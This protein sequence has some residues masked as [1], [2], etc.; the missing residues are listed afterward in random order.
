M[1]ATRGRA[2]PWVPY[3]VLA[4]SACFWGSGFLFGKIALE[5][6]GVG[7]MLV[8][9]FLFGCAALAPFALRDRTPVRRAHL[10][11]FALTALVGIPVQYIVQFEGLA[12]TTV[13][14]ASL[15]IGTV[16][17]LLAGAAVVFSRE[18]LDR[19][20]WLLLG[21][22]TLG[23]A[24]IAGSAAGSGSGKGDPT[25]LGD[26]LVVVSVLGGVAWVLLSK[27]LM[28]PLGYSAFVVNAYVVFLG[29]A[30]LAVWVFMVDGPP[31]VD[32]SA[33]TWSCLVAPGILTT[34]LGSLLW[35]WGVSHVP[36][37]RAAAFVN[38]DPVVGTIL[39]VLV[40]GERLG[41]T[42]I[43]GGILILGAALRF[44]LHEH[45]AEAATPPG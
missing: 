35:N 33:R 36:A 13:S 28:G 17:L 30:M 16:P 9:R 44:T 26:A 37:T 14:H 3:A 6:L 4:L 39:G 19:T 5:E 40:L 7:H 38:I 24:L 8:Y 41:A 31:P 1:I 2:K 43:V 12:R 25:L 15:M 18:R 23:A 29:T 22:S 45:P 34:A 21:V 27:R 20:G 32:L 10:G 11:L 42:A